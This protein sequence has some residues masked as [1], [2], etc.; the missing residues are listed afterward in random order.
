MIH[1]IDEHSLLRDFYALFAEVEC[2]R[3]FNF[4]DKRHDE[5]LRRRVS[6]YFF[7][8]TQF[9]GDYSEDDRPLGFAGVLIDEPLYGT[10]LF[11]L[12]AVLTHIGVIQE[13]RRTK[14]GSDI[15]VAIE[16]YALNQGAYCIYTSTWARSTEAITFY[17]ANG[18]I[19]IATLPD[20]YGPNY[21][22]DTYLRKVLGIKSDK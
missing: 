5:W 14:H 16:K 17:L 4:S 18:Y 9:F 8:G 13:F 12:K 1:K 22:G 15:L 10:E 19:P 6:R 21:E 11:N 7:S 20:V 3:L 2:G